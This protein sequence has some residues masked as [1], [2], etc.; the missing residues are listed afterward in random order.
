MLQFI[1]AEYFTICSKS[2]FLAMTYSIKKYMLLGNNKIKFNI[3]I[4]VRAALGE[5]S[6]QKKKIKL[7]FKA[8]TL[9]AKHVG[10]RNLMKGLIL[11]SCNRNR[12]S[13]SINICF[14]AN[15]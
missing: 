10:N 15:H 11:Q 1:V 3:N 6:I 9:F 13:L 4:N 12:F 14:A 5:S 2:G 7:L 8:T